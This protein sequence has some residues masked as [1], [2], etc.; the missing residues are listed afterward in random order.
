[1]VDF[2]AKVYSVQAVKEAA[3]RFCD[4]LIVAIE[5]APG[6]RIR[7]RIESLKRLPPEALDAL[8]ASFQIEVLDNDLRGTLRHE[9]EPLRNFILSLAFSKADLDE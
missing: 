8:V 5:M 4:R 1:M 2:D 7:C 3:Y 6:D 9:T